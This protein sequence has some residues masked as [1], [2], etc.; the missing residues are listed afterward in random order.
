VV[1][2]LTLGLKPGVRAK[3]HELYVTQSLPLQRKWKIDVIDHGPSRHDDD[4][5]YVVRR[6]ASLAD[7]E[8]VE[9]AFYGSDDWKLGPRA[10]I[11]GMIES[12][13]FIVVPVANLGQW[14]QIATTQ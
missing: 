12:L 11:L 13:S 2:I 14:H 6:F 7:R 3:F 10:A 5:Y 4:S 9:E 8:R 1:E